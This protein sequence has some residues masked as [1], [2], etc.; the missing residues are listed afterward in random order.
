MIYRFLNYGVLGRGLVYWFEVRGLGTCWSL[1]LRS[2]CGRCCWFLCF[3]PSC[4]F[5]L[6][7]P[8]YQWWLREWD[9]SRDFAAGFKI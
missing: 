2:A 8:D 1:A 6:Q 7:P 4:L 5:S 9:T 3:E